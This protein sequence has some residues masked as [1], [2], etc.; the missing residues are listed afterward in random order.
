M[1]QFL[2]EHGYL[3]PNRTRFLLDLNLPPPPHYRWE[4]GDDGTE[5]GSDSPSLDHTWTSPGPTPPNPL[6]LD[7]T[8]QDLTPPSPS[9]LPTL[10]REGGDGCAEVADF[11]FTPSSPELPL[12]IPIHDSALK[13]MPPGPFRPR[14]SP[15]PRRLMKSHCQTKHNKHMVL[16]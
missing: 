10:T 2:H 7:S 9:H 3:G 11:H 16:N 13:W 5:T 8:D 1:S 6:S 14:K 12:W 4:G 15:R